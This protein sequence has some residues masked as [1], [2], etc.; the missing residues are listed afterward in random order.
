MQFLAILTF[1]HKGKKESQGYLKMQR[2]W[3][4]LQ[5]KGSYSSLKSGIGAKNAVVIWTTSSFVDNKR[6]VIWK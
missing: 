3:Q 5:N 6:S 4:F 2:Q 1:L